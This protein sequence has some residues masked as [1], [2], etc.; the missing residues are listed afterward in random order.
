MGA[1]R[2]TRPTRPLPG[3]LPF[4]R[5][6]RPS[7]R[8]G[9]LMTLRSDVPQFWQ[10]GQRGCVLGNRRECKIPR[11][12]WK[13]PNRAGPLP[14][15]AATSRPLG[16]GGEPHMPPAWIDRSS[17]GA[18]A[19]AGGGKGCFRGPFHTVRAY[20]YCR[21]RHHVGP[22][23]S[24]RTSP[25]SRWPSS[26]WRKAGRSEASVCNICNAS[27]CDTSRTRRHEW[28]LLTSRTT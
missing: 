8:S 6:A 3:S 28:R 19:I 23:S 15:R 10:P 11:A 9:C 17:T 13:L 24:G 14:H 21:I 26:R 16:C 7:S 2:P 1:T 5:L 27:P 12:T 18:T 20:P 22:N 25:F 4:E